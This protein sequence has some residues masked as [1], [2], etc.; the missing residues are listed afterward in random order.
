[1]EVQVFGIKKSPD[2][3]KALRFFSERRIRTHFVDFKE[4]GPSLGELKRFAQ[5]FGLT[6]LIDRESARYAELGLKH[7]RLSDERWIELLCNEPL[8]LR[9][10]LTRSGSLLSIGLNKDQWRQWVDDDKA[11]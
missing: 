6:A 9:M 1:M 11:L 2:T 7:S 10:P 5:K 8:V 3:R 4:R